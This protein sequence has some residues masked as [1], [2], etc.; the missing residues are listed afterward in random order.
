MDNLKEKIILYKKLLP[1]ILEID[2]KFRD[3]ILSKLSTKEKSEIFKVLNEKRKSLERQLDIYKNN[4]LDLTQKDLTYEDLK[5]LD[6][7]ENSK[8][9][10]SYNK[11]KKLPQLRN[12]SYKI[13][14]NPVSKKIY[15][16]REFNKDYTFTKNILNKNV[17]LI[18][19]PKGTLLF[20]Q[21][22]NI[23]DVKY[24]FVG[25]KKPENEENF[26][27]HPDHKSYF[28][29]FP[30]FKTSIGDYGN[31]DVIFVLQQD[32]VLFYPVKQDII[33]DYYTENIKDTS[34]KSSIKL[35]FDSKNYLK[36]EYINQNI[37]GWYVNANTNLYIN[38]NT[39]ELEKYKQVYKG[40][41]YT[42]SEVMLYPR[43]QRIF[44]DVVTK[45][46]DFN[47]SWLEKNLKKF[48][49]KPLVIFDETVTSKKY[50]EI[51]DKLLSVK[52]FTNEDGT[53][54]ITVNK[55]D[56]TYIL[57]EEANEDILKDCVPLSQD[58]VEYL[59]EYV[60]SQK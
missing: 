22:H 31:I 53:F 15:N 32:V 1:Q 58:R 43:K 54:H 5:L 26:Y 7:P 39:I 4:E 3:T 9:N 19:L 36:D 27:L 49:Y 2:E 34:M 18:I 42:R 45:V 30:S 12:I 6:L 50:K 38:N 59:K 24:S 33:K 35:Q 23:D 16:F 44:E 17:D 48:N 55:I 51:F 41:S 13:L 14:R 40:K 37:M 47:D 52:G 56:G 60:A 46:E 20:R 57:A 25:Y 11:I 8:V 21:Y 10:L 29:S 28:Y